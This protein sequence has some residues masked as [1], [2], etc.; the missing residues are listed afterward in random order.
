M[1][2]A[3]YDL[4]NAK[5]ELS[6][7]AQ[8]GKTLST[9]KVTHGGEIEVAHNSITSW[10]DYNV[11]LLQR[12]FTTGEIADEYQCSGPA[13]T[14]SFDLSG[15]AP[16][17][18]YNSDLETLRGRLLYLESL[19]GRVHLLAP[20]R[21]AEALA[22]PTTRPEVLAEVPSRVFIVHGQD[23][24]ARESVARFLERAGVKAVIL[25]EQASRGDTVIEK[26]ERNSDV[27]FAVVLLTGD[28]EGRRKGDTV[29]PKPRARQNVILEL[30]YFAAKLGRANVCALYE[31]GVELPSD[32]NGVVWVVLDGHD[33]WKYRLA[34]EL[35][36]AGFTIDLNRI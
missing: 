14:V 3:D 10:D 22:F 17:Y 13:P 7:R 23:G 16:A 21:K 6:E 2:A 5:A 4:E 9:A 35:R 26:L 1:L 31:D 25:Q 36:A 27:H 20:R 30:G 29:P 28:D 11:T 34:K 33:A 8:L 15:R 18:D 12:M 32:W 19:L 24:A